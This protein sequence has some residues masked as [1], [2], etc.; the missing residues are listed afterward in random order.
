MFK[1]SNDLFKKKWNYLNTRNQ[2]KGKIIVYGYSRNLCSFKDKWIRNVVIWVILTKNKSRRTYSVWYDWY[3]VSVGK[4]IYV[5]KRWTNVI[6]STYSKLVFI[7]GAKDRE[8]WL[9]SGMQGASILLSSA[10][11]LEGKFQRGVTWELSVA[12]T[13]STWG[14]GYLY[15]IVGVHVGTTASTKSLEIKP[16][17]TLG[18]PGEIYKLPL[19]SLYAG[20]IK[21]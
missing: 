20:P 4:Q 9:W 7:F 14:N 17:C 12:I 15:P 13:A 18:W 5:T 6:Q 11:G 10:R 3:G 19:P 21:S 2:K 1:S 8:K 16:S